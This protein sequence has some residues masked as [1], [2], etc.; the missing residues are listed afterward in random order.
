ML[1]A[2]QDELLKN[3]LFIEQFHDNILR[4][5]VIDFIPESEFEDRIY[6]EEEII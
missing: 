5:N 6:I 4:A 1:K 2:L 3:N